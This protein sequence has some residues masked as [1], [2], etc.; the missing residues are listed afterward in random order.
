MLV[1]VGRRT[2]AVFSRSTARGGVVA[3]FEPNP[4]AKDRPL[5]GGASGV[6][7]EGLE[8]PPGERPCC[9]TTC[10]A[11]RNFPPPCCHCPLPRRRP[12]RQMTPPRRRSRRR[13][14]RLT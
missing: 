13:P 2:A 6:D 9:P 11:R 8:K 12:P 5:D 10:R 3:L 1:R 4:L 14:A 7:N